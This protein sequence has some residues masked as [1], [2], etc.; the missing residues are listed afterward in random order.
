M[1]V[2]AFDR[3]HR[4]HE[5]TLRQHRRWLTLRSS[6]RQRFFARLRAALIARFGFPAV[7]LRRGTNAV[8]PHFFH[9]ETSPRTQT[10]SAIGLPRNLSQNYL[11]IY[12]PELKIIELGNGRTAW[13]S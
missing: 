3:W 12:S 5:L 7:G 9:H 2:G 6:C 11:L 4:P 1:A 13:P 8:P 10:G